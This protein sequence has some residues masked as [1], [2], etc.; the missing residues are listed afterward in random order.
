MGNKECEQYNN[1]DELVS[2]LENK[3]ESHNKYCHYTTLPSL[4]SIIQN[5]SFQLTH[6][7]SFQLNDLQE[8]KIK[9]QYSEW[10][11]TYLTSF[12]FRS[13][14]ESVAMW[15][16]YGIPRGDAIC[17]HIPKRN[18]LKLKESI[19]SN[20]AFVGSNHIEIKQ[21]RL[22]DLAYIDSKSTKLCRGSGNKIEFGSEIK[23]LDKNKEVTGM[24]KND[25]WDHE[26]ETRLLIR[27]ER[28]S[29]DEHIYVS[30][31]DDFFKGV[32]IVMGPCFEGNLVDRLMQ[33]DIDIEQ[34]GCEIKS[35]DLTNYVNI[36][37]MCSLCRNNF[38]KSE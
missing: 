35:S 11:Y 16:M 30:L 1:I 14:S 37:D 9:G 28:E 7:T 10:L 15:S 25:A 27:T 38:E 6:G 17:L 36:R 19:I 26:K 31:P 2:G 22:V 32:T 12:S 4:K 23:G 29:R 18:M 20:G 33:F 8:S 24:I 3:G 21:V 34:M 13:I 5:N